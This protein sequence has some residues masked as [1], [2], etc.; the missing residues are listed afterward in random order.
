[1]DMKKAFTLAEALITMMVISIIAAM[2]IPSLT[3]NI[4]EKAWK[5]QQLAFYSRMTEAISAFDKLSGY[6]DDPKTASDSFVVQGL[7]RMYKISSVCNIYDYKA[8]GISDTITLYDG[9]TKMEFPKTLKDLNPSLLSGGSSKTNEIAGS[10]VNTNAAFFITVNGDS[11]AAFYNP[12][13]GMKEEDT[14][15]VKN[16]MCVN[17]IY[18]INGLKG[19]N[20]MG[21]DLGVLTAFYS[22]DHSVGSPIMVNVPETSAHIASTSSSDKSGNLYCGENDARVPTLEELASLYVN[23]SLFKMSKSITWSS[24]RDTASS[25]SGWVINMST[26]EAS[27]SDIGSNHTVR[28]V[29]KLKQ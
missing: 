5:K 18:D 29:E 24:T 17:F 1:M 22:D 3:T 4:Q 14:F 26:G 7:S 23:G 15:N 10:I 19:P 16:K 12:E 9:K 8:C 20:K 11:V 27:L 6:G 21:K 25:Y 2:T 28:C 13:C